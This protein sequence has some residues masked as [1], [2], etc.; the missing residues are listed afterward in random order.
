MRL[1]YDRINAKVRQLLEPVKT[2]RIQDCYHF[3]GFRYG[4]FG[5]NPYEDYIVGLANGEPLPR[6]R[7]A[8]ARLMLEYRPRT[9]SE[10]L[11]LD[12]GAWPAWQLPWNA[13]RRTPRPPIVDPRDNPDI[14]CHFC[15]AGVLA[16]HIN[17]EF[18]WLEGAYATISARG[19]QPERFGYIRC[20]ELI[21]PGR[22]AYLV[23]DGNHRLSALHA[24]GTRNVKVQTSSGVRR[25]QAERWPAVRVGRHSLTE[26]L[27]IFDRY[28][29]LDNRAL[30]PMNSGQL[31]VDEAPRW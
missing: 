12:I 10:A 4:G 2:V 20:I 14:V 1:L 21:A 19:Y 26:A 7:A 24:M 16:S 5:N 18:G 8:F 13:W 15:A 17:R 23:L 29:E 11:D 6:L 25:D 28:F 31:I 9:M 27:R 22:S 30:K 3:R